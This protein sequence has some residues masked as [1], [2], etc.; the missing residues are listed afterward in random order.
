MRPYW[1]HSPS[2]LCL[3]YEG[4]IEFLLI[5]F[6]NQL[7][8]IHNTSLDTSH[9][10]RDLGF[11]FECSCTCM[12]TWTAFTDY[13]PD[14]FFWA[15]R[16]LSLVFPYFLFLC[17]SI[18]GHLVSFWAHGNLPYSIVSNEPFVDCFAREIFCDARCLHGKNV[19]R[20]LDDE[21]D[22][23]IKLAKRTHRSPYTDAAISKNFIIY[24][25]VKYSLL[26]YHV[27]LNSLF[28]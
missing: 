5:R 28:V 25:R 4:H 12:A 21:R 10:A 19:D 7:A 26:G 6:K 2:F 9:S 23:S 16:F 20:N 15:T 18:D 11:I 13:S 3:Y 22:N 8:K 14:R 1:K 17:R 27:S 24:H